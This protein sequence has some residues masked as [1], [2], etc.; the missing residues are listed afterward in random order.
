MVVNIKIGKMCT[1]VLWCI[2]TKD[3]TE[4]CSWQLGS[5]DWNPQKRMVEGVRD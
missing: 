1:C 5:L 3:S 4:E 2:V